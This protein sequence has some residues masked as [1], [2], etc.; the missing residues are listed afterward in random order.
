MN[1]NVDC[2]VFELLVNVDRLHEKCGLNSCPTFR[3]NDEALALRNG[4]FIDE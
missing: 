4:A 3:D 1:L 2:F